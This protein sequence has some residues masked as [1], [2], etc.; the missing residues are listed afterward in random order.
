MTQKKPIG[1]EGDSLNLSQATRAA[2]IDADLRRVMEYDPYPAQVKRDRRRQLFW[3]VIFLAATVVLVYFGFPWW[4]V[5]PGFLCLFKLFMWLALR[6]VK[7]LTVYKNG[8]LVPAVVT[9]TSPLQIMALSEM[10]T[11]EE[12]PVC[13]GMKRFEIKALPGHE[14]KVGER[15]PCAALFGGAMLAKVWSNIEAHPVCW[16]TG[17]RSVISRADEAIGEEEWNVLNELLPAALKHPKIEKGE[18]VYFND[19]LS[20]RADLY[21]PQK[22]TNE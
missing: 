12:L 4:S 3:L 7:P 6:N 21:E 2:N 14:L 19:D 16:G 17:D 8:L 5:I 10:Q 20:E 22:K 13:W 1:G 9:Q 11:S 15:V 18:C